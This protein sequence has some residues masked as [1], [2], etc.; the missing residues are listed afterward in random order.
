MSF[1]RIVFYVQKS[2]SKV[3][4]YS[5]TAPSSL[6]GTEAKIITD[7][8]GIAL[9]DWDKGSKQW[10]DMTPDA[11]KPG[12]YLL[13]VYDGD[14]NLVAIL[15]PP[16][17]SFKISGGGAVAFSAFMVIGRLIAGVHWATDILGSVLL[18]AGLFLL[19]VSAV[20]FA[21]GK[22]QPAKGEERQ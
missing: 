17:P 1:G 12:D 7:F 8:S 21:D 13:F 4:N 15:R 2:D 20:S 19:Y 5:D 3:S 9:Y 14:G 10:A 16:Q 18:S 22:K 11:I 6:G